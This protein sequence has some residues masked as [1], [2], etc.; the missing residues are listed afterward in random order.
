MVKFFEARRCKG[1]K[2]VKYDLVQRCLDDPF[3]LFPI[4]FENLV[5]CRDIA[6]TGTA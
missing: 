5:R 6:G 3:E 2:R 1:R 4:D